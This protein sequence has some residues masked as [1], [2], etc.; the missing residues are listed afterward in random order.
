ME[1]AACGATTP[2][3]Q[4][5]NNLLE[6]S[7]QDLTT[8]QKAA[9]AALLTNFA[10]LSSSTSDDIGRAGVVKHFLDTGSA[11]PVRQPGRSLPI[12]QRTEAD[13]DT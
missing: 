6:R 1:Q 5:L 9:V 12:H 10:D 4:Y 7:S 13:A 2:L 3:P 8:E 11:S